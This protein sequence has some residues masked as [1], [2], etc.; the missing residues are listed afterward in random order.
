MGQP[1]KLFGKVDVVHEPLAKALVTALETL[2]KENQPLPKKLVALSSVGLCPYDENRASGVRN[3]IVWII[4]FVQ[5]SYFTLAFV[6]MI[7]RGAKG[8][9]D[10]VRE[11]EGILLKE[12]PKFNI[13]LA[14]VRPPGLT[15]GAMT[16]K[17]RTSPGKMVENTG[18]VS[19]A[20]LADYMIDLALEEKSTNQFYYISE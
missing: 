1:L 11:M 20:D 16:G 5:A 10:D 13:E 19:R 15:D 2:Q 7:K 8:V 6:A 14:I 18:F 9:Y 17:Y 4:D 3:L 12:L